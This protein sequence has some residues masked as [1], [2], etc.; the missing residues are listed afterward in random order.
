MKA[1]I[2]DAYRA[3][4]DPEWLARWWGPAGFTNPV[5]RLDAR[6]GGS[7][8]VEMTDPSGPVYPMNG[9]FDILE[10]PT[11]LVFRT[12]ALDAQGRQIL[13][14]VNEVNFEDLGGGKTRLRLYVR[15]T[16]ALVEAKDHLKGMSI[17]WNMSLDKLVDHFAPGT[18]AASA[19]A[20][21]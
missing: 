15:M 3:W 12:G 5:C 8:Y 9:T 16:L 14:G 6:P 1:N 19:H 21:R 11:R 10:P 17:G 18:S 2:Q 7:I 13:E 20:K 4:T